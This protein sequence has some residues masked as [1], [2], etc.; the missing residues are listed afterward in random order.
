MSLEDHEKRKKQRVAFKTKITLKT[1]LSELN[2]E[3]SSKDLS[4]KGVFI[5]TNENIALNTKCDIEIYLTGMTEKFVLNM[6]GS[7]IRKENS[8][9]AVEFTT[10]DLDSYTH[11]KNI[12]RYN[13][14]NPEDIY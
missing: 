11:L 8:G 13:T 10:M 6:H 4:L 2:I 1:D 7:V 3:G 14:Q 5:H 9:I 12:L